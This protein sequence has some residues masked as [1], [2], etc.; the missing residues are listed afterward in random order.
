M[1][2]DLKKKKC[3]TGSVIMT[4]CTHSVAH[5]TITVLYNHFP[6]CRRGIVYFFFRCSGVSFLDPI[7]IV[8]V[9]DKQ[10]FSFLPLSHGVLCGVCLSLLLAVFVPN[11]PRN[12]NANFFP[13]YNL[14]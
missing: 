7:T 3:I 11:R 12:G 9:C 2:S 13:S 14:I 6:A 5:Q 8:N 10:K 4:F 1:V